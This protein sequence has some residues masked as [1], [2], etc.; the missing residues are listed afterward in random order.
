MKRSAV[1]TREFAQRETADPDAF[2]DAGFFTTEVWTARALAAEEDLATSW[3]EKFSRLFSG[4]GQ[5][6]RAGPRRRHAAL[7]ESQRLLK[8]DSPG[9]P[10]LLALT[11]PP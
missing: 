3:D 10:R 7:V 4:V 2:V 8:T 5:S 6:S 1:P 9:K 11:P